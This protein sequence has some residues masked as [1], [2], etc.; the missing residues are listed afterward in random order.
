MVIQICD[1]IVEY[2]IRFKLYMSTK[3]ANPKFSPDVYSKLTVV[4]F[5]ATSEGLCEQMLSTVV[6]V[7]VPELESQSEQLRREVAENFKA[8]AEVEDRVL[9]LLTNVEGRLLDDD[10]LVMTLMVRVCACLC[11]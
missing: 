7:E 1:A 8:V 2:D 11:G 10:S 6:S 9:E 4:N 5:Q 3:L